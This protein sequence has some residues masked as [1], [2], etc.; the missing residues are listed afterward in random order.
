MSEE[1]EEQQYPSLVDQGKNLA[2]FS[3]DLIKHLQ[4]SQNHTA[5]FVSDETYAER[6]MTCRG[7]DRYDELENRCREC[8]CFVPAKAKIIL[9][10][11]PLNK[12]KVDDSNWETTFNEIVSNMENDTLDKTP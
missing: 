7:C 12:W 1:S 11:C 4:K 2:R 3:W 6:T 8:G 5:L 9:D 10:S